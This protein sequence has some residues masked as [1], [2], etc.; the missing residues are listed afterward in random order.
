MAEGGE[1]YNSDNEYESDH[2]LFDSGSE[3]SSEDGRNFSAKR[4][5]I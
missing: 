3:D 2:L 5:F 1:D 4:L